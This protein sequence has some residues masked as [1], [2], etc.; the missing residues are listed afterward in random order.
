VE[1]GSRT[2]ARSPGVASA[3]SS[4]PG[5][6]VDTNIFVRH[7]TADPPEQAARATRFLSEAQNLLLA[8]LVVAE[9]AYVLESEYGASR[10]QVAASLRAILA[11]PAIEAVDP[12][13]LQ[14]SIEVYDVLGLDFAEAYLVAS[15]ERS[16]VG[17]V[18]S[19]D[20]SIDRVGTVR[21]LEP[22]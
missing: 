3:V 1:Q 4:R 14:R 2:R 21:R 15:A 13:L 10:P 5:A 8:D 7:L 11:F 9:T 6:F 19:F 16:G 12:E 17:V 18:A 20:Q 22:A